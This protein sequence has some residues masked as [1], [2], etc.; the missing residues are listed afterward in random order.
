MLTLFT[1]ISRRLWT[2]P[3]T[4][5]AAATTPPRFIETLRHADS[6]GGVYRNVKKFSQ[7]HTSLLVPQETQDTLIGHFTKLHS[8]PPPP[9]GTRAQLLPPLVAAPA[10]SQ[11]LQPTLTEVRLA[12]TSLRNGRMPGPDG[13]EAELLKSADS[14][15][16][17]IHEIVKRV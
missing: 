3:T 8:P 13:V 1:V 12:V 5:F 15:L 9:D 6:I 17:H 11:L 14:L 2:T 4:T 16:P 7:L 10:E